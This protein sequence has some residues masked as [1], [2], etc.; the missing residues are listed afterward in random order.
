MSF[1]DWWKVG[2]DKAN[3]VFE[4]PGEH[5]DELETSVDL[6]LVSDFVHLERGNS[7]RVNTSRL[8]AINKGWVSIARPWHLLTE[9]STAGDPQRATRENRESYIQLVID[10]LA[11]YVVELDRSR[12]NARFSYRSGF[13]TQG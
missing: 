3:K 11:Q 6:A 13:R 12:M 2:S 1:A 4:N 7:S 8:E 10:R 9:D 5:A